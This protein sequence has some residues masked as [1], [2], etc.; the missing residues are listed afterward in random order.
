MRKIELRCACG[1]SPVVPIEKKL[2]LQYILGYWCKTT[3]Q[4]KAGQ[5]KCS[6]CVQSEGIQ[7]ELDPRDAS[8]ALTE[9]QAENNATPA[10]R[11]DKPEHEIRT[12]I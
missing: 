3:K 6:V 7:C 4:L 5:E 12:R 9:W 1:D 11:N 10:G 8:G 2:L